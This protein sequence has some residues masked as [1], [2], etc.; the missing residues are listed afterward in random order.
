[1]ESPILQVTADA[2]AQIKKIL[3]QEELAEQAVRVGIA[4]KSPTGFQYQ[5]EFCDRSERV[6]SDVLMEQDGV[7]FYVDG[8]SVEDLRGTT[9]DYVDTG[10]SAGFKFDNPNKPK[11]LQDP[12]AERV[13]RVI[14]ERVNPGVASHG[15]H[16]TLLDVQDGTAYVRLGGGC[17]G[18]GHADTTVKDGIQTMICESVPE[19]HTVLDVTDHAA[20]TNPYFQG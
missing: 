16:V 15:G 2:T 5:L 17:Q 12:I 3:E 8:E 14:Q 13:H 1:M 19:I 9:L 20:G 18:C 6:E 10:F 4:E 11:L 7:V